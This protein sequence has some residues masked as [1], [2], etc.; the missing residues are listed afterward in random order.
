MGARDDRYIEIKE[1]LF[2]EEYGVVQGQHQLLRATADVPGALGAHGHP[3]H[4]YLCSVVS[5]NGFISAFIVG[6]AE[7][8]V[9]VNW[10][11]CQ[12]F[13][14]RRCVEYSVDGGFHFAIV[15]SGGMITA[16][17]LTLI[18]LPVLYYIVELSWLA[19]FQ[20]KTV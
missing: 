2:P 18:V 17:F 9:G 5:G 4:R 8:A 19:S 7:S 11:C 1:G 14:H 20:C 15:I 6:D 12:Y 3:P 10:G 13:P 16:T